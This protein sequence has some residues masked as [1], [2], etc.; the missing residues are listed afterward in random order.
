MDRLHGTPDSPAQEAPRL[1]LQWS[2]RTTDRQD[3]STPERDRRR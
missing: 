2:A 1:L 3:V